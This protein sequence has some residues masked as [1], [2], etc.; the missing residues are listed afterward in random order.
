MTFSIIARDPNTQEIG[1]A[2]S[3]ANLAVGA[4][5]YFV[6]AGVGVVATQAEPHPIMAQKGL[7]LLEEG[8]TA[9]ETLEIMLSADAEK[10][11]RQTH[12]LDRN[13]ETAARTGDCVGWA[14]HKTYEN[15]SVAGNM[16]VGEAPL[17]AMV[18]K[19][20]ASV[21]CVFG[22]RLLRALEAGQAA[23]G[24]KR[25]KQSAALYVVSTEPYADIDLRVDDHHDPVRELI[26]LY[27]ESQKQYYLEFRQRI[28]KKN[29]ETSDDKPSIVDG[30]GSETPAQTRKSE[31][32]CN[33]IAN[34]LL[35]VRNLETRFFTDDGV[36]N[37]V[38]GISYHL[39]A[40]ET[41]AIVGESGCG[42]TIGV[43]SLIGLIPSPP[44][45]VTGGTVVFNGQ[46]LTNSKRTQMEDIRGRDIGMVFQDPSMSL[47][48]VLPVSLQITEVLT[49]HM[50]MTERQA[51]KRGIELL[52]MVNIPQAEERF[53]NYPHEFSGGIR[54]RIM[55]AIAIACMPKL[56]IADEPTTALD[57]TIAAGLIDLIK[58]LR[59]EL[60]TA[61]I[62]ITHDLAVVAGLADRVIVMYAGSIVEEGP[63][64]D[65]Y[66][67]PKH[68]YTEGLL[69]SV[70][71][72]D[73]V[74]EGRL[75]TIGGLPPDL[76]H[77]PKSCAFA[78]RC[79]Y[80][81]DKCWEQ[82]PALMEVSRNRKSACWLTEKVGEKIG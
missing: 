39:D 33:V 65:I 42:K 46:E 59:E 51:R 74:R 37:A 70:P 55:I 13:G 12:L 71:R 81:Q 40:G 62:W 66:K 18:E 58:R 82:A 68:P 32:E 8:T 10:H 50:G 11:R 24:D 16:L 52:E 78:P 9:Q 14:G 77:L 69:N 6:K 49:R 7:L 29:T 44:G 1:I 23:G 4:V 54:Q 76:I 30:I 67:N 5:G 80:A 79:A 3:T 25:G 19:Y 45:R 56:I 53:D 38:N 57:V 22:E 26:R 17:L 72:L 36:V 43:L 75:S 47:T 63:V 15:L 48:P 34:H 61:V 60:K 31:Q 20:Q 28:P 27:Q 64:K 73:V 21:E 35:E 41:L 2:V